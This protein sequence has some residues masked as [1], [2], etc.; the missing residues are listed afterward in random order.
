MLALHCRTKSI[1]K[2]SNIAEGLGSI[3]V[4]LS[5]TRAGAP[6]LY[7]PKETHGVL[8]DNPALQQGFVESIKGTLV[9]YLA[10][11]QQARAASLAAPSRFGSQQAGAATPP[12]PNSQQP[13]PSDASHPGTYGGQHGG[14]A[15][16]P[17]QLHS[18][19]LQLQTLPALVGNSPSQWACRLR[20]PK[21]KGQA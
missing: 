10:Q 17:R 3:S 9:P 12:L 13:G 4:M 8:R 14:G 5:I 15:R 16:R 6:R 1:S 20:H 18:P 19:Q 21:V 2:H 11:L 7:A